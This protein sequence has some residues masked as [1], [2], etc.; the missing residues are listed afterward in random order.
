MNVLSRQKVF[1]LQKTLDA[2][3]ELRGTVALAQQYLTNKL[4]LASLADAK[5][6]FLLKSACS[7][8]CFQWRPARTDSGSVWCH[9]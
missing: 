7:V 5:E 1:R 4:K 6:W 8:G 3:L 9:H 2:V